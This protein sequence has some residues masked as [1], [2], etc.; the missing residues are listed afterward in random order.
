MSQVPYDQYSKSKERKVHCVQLIQFPTLHISELFHRESWIAAG[1]FSGNTSWLTR[2]NFRHEYS[3][4]VLF[5][6]H[7]SLQKQSHLIYLIK[8]QYTK[9]MYT[10]RNRIIFHFPSP[11]LHVS[12][13]FVYHQDFDFSIIFICQ[14]HDETIKTISNRHMYATFLSRRKICKT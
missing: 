9:C 8:S 2:L 10:Y 13:L 12:L 3:S 6:I 1:S 5:V 4:Y 7:L 14:I 11:T